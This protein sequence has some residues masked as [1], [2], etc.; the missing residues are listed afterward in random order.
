MKRP[1][2]PDPII[3]PLVKGLE[4]HPIL[5][6]ELEAELEA[7]VASSRSPVRSITPE[8]SPWD[9]TH[10][11]LDQASPQSATQLPRK[12]LVNRF[13]QARSLK[14]KSE[15][16]YRRD[17]QHF[18]DWTQ[19]P[20]GD[21]T[22][23]QVA[24]FKR[25]LLQ[26]KKLA[27]NSVNR[28]LQTLKSFYRWMGVSDS[29]LADPTKIVKL[30]KVSETPSQALT[31]EEVE[32]IYTAIQT[33]SRDPIRDRALFSMLLHGLRAEEAI[34]LNFEDYNGQKLQIQGKQGNILGTVSLTDEGQLALD[35]YTQQR[36]MQMQSAGLELSPKS[37]LFV[38]NSNR[39]QGKRLT[40]WGVQEIMN[41]LAQQTQINLHSHRGRYTFC[42]H[43]MLKPEVD[44]ASA[45]DQSRYQD[46]RSL[47][48]Y[49]ER[50]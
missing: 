15:Q 41:R 38:S 17:L 35:A 26:D 4:E 2:V 50:S 12:S 43:L 23:R 46:R 48:R 7:E 45:L 28:I 36:R 30:E 40:Y 29:M 27:P 8:A 22:E 21:I 13:I 34:N 33:R 5:D 47:K 3:V 10:P 19:Q 32:Q 14:P 37:P 9:D 25:H 6:A 11:T 42:V 39:S 24:Q 31:D 20:W 1:T 49:E 44:T 16:A 18:M